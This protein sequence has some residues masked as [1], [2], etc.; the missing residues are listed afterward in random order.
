MA[1]KHS[2]TKAALA[3]APTLTRAAR[4]TDISRVKAIVETLA[5]VMNQE[6]D[7]FINRGEDG[8]LRWIAQELEV[9]FLVVK[10]SYENFVQ[11]Y[12][13]LDIND[14]VVGMEWL[15]SHHVPATALQQRPVTRQ[16]EW[17]HADEKKGA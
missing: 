6:N 15:R 2:T 13:N 9:P 17:E 10:L 3:N 4:V 14:V 8:P 12:D 11:D 7:L 5:A 16:H 1:K